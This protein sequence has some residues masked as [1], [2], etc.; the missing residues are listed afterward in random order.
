MAGQALVC[1]VVCKIW[2]FRT[3]RAVGRAENMKGQVTPNPSKVE[4]YMYVP[5]M[6]LN[7]A[8]V[9]CD[10]FL[11]AQEKKLARKLKFWYLLKTYFHLWKW[12]NYAAEL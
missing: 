2:Y 4:G 8:E 3:I 7:W 1:T 10:L 5:V 11:P 6:S 12:L 9:F